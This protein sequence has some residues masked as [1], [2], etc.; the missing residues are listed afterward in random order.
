M[1]IGASTSCYYPLETEKSLANLGRLGFSVCEVFF[2]SFSELDKPF[3]TELKAIRD[4]YGLRISAVHP[5]FS[6]AEPYLL[7]SEY[8]RRF[9]DSLELY[10]RYFRAA[11]DLGANI[12]VLH[13]GKVSKASSEE[14]YFD[15]FARLAELGASH[16]VIVAQENV[17][18]YRSESP[19]F[20]KRMRDY[21][22]PEFRMV[23]DIKQAARAGFSAFEFTQT[24]A[25]SIVHVHVSDKLPD[26]DCLPPGDGEF[27]FSRLFSRFSEV[28]FSG[29]YIVELYRHNFEEDRQ[30]VEAKA[31]LDRIAEKLTREQNPEQQD[32]A[33]NC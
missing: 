7:F 18:H 8:E 6:F 28:G 25:E 27:D 5:F 20:L 26:K 33:C 2:N 22:G 17:V 31:H 14:L 24:L 10:K 21:I 23:L 29:D 30:I 16:G 11:G 15:R 32:F 3:L 9:T 12:L 4:V 19:A 1:G 13:G